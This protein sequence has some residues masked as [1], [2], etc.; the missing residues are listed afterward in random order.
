MAKTKTGLFEK[1]LKKELGL[2]CVT[3]F[4]FHP[5]RRWRAD[6]AI[7]SHKILIEVEGAVWV[8]GR[9]TRGSGFVKDLQKYN[10]ATAMG[11]SVLRVQPKD[12]MS[13]ELIDL[14]KQ[15]ISNKTKI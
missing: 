13:T 6:Y 2:D 12:L 10:T 7:L 11:Y 14:L 15:T 4:R 8:Q 9:H 1:V 3:E 5:V